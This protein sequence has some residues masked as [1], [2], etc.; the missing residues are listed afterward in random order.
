MWA[1]SGAVASCISTTGM[2][3]A[4]TGHDLSERAIARQMTMSPST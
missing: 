3:N 4:T 1:D 2:R